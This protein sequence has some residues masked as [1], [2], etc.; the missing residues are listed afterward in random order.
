VATDCPLGVVLISG[1]LVTLP[2]MMALLKFIALSY[3][4]KI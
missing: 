2:M 3:F 1:S 4:V